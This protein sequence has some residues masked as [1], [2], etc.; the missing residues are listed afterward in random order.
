MVQS[1]HDDNQSDSA[2]EQTKFLCHQQD[3]P[4][5]DSPLKDKTTA[6][7]EIQFET[8][9]PDLSSVYDGLDTGWSWVVLFATFMSFVVLGGCV[10][11]TGVVHTILLERFRQSNAT[12]AWVA[13]LFSA[14][15]SLAGKVP[16]L[17]T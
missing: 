2:T 14:L 6:G 13:S 17:V 9:T 12:T 16:C 3:G 7:L 8:A 15:S 10:Y 1:S 5:V 4:V 11:T